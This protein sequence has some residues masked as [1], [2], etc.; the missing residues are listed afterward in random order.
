MRFI[1]LNITV[2]KCNKVHSF[3]TT[4]CSVQQKLHQTLNC[5]CRVWSIRL[6]PLIL[7]EASC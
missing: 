4:P 5:R 3:V 6:I 1:P 2:L 7:K